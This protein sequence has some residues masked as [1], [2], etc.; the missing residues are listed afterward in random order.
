MKAFMH[1]SG[2]FRTTSREPRKEN[3]PEEERTKEV[4][5]EVQDGES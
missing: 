3:G 1:K 5:P 4:N 2:S